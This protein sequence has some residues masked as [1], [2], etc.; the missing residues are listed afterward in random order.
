MVLNF[1][2]IDRLDVE[3]LQVDL[4][5]LFRSFFS[6]FSAHFHFYKVILPVLILDKKRLD[7]L[8]SQPGL[9]PGVDLH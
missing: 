7:F 4:L 1:L 3:L 5:S 2:C 9:R 8:W 6:P